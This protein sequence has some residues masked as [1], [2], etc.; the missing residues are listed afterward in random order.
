MDVKITDECDNKRALFGKEKCVVC[1]Q[2]GQFILLSFPRHCTLLW[3]FAM[4][5]T[6]ML[7]SFHPLKCTLVTKWKEDGLCSTSVL[8]CT[9]CIMNSDNYVAIQCILSLHT[10]YYCITVVF[11]S[12]QQNSV[13]WSPVSLHGHHLTPIYIFHTEQSMW[14]LMHVC[15]LLIK[16]FTSFLNRAM[17]FRWL[18][19][20]LFLQKQHNSGL[21]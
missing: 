6:Q 4:W 14:R 9:I 11:N 18:I 15:A 7:Y 1:L 17:L 10:V 3:C 16:A 2:L 20:Y 12:E 5:Q 21:S 8:F 13:N 19:T